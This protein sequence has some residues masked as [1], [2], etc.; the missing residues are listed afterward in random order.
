MHFYLNVLFIWPLG[1]WKYR[2]LTQNSEEVRSEWACKV[3]EIKKTLQN[4]CLIDHGMMELKLKSDDTRKIYVRK[5][6]IFLI[7][8]VKISTSWKGN[9]KH[10]RFMV[11]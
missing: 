3:L 6:V 9:S 8:E 1:D 10:L 2:V 4:S 7:C 5:R 11:N